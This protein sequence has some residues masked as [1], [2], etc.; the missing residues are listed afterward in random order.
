M[1]RD[2]TRTGEQLTGNL[3]KLAQSPSRRPARHAKDDVSVAG[4]WFKP[5]DLLL[6][7][8]KGARYISWVLEPCR[9]I[10]ISGLHGQHGSR[11]SM[12]CWGRAPSDAWARWGRPLGRG[13]G[14]VN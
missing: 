6:S 11:R 7:L 12:G 3:L 5:T 4:G 2:R 9:Q 10:S 14:G 13:T 8:T 1:V